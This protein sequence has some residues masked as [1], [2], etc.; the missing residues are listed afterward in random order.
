MV[1]KYVHNRFKLY[2]KSG[3][4]LQYTAFA[5]I[6]GALV[7]TVAINWERLLQFAIQNNLIKN[8][9]ICE[10]LVSKGVPFY[11]PLQSYYHSSYNR[12]NFDHITIAGQ[13]HHGMKRVEVWQQA[14]SLGQNTSIHRHDCEEVFVILSGAGQL[15]AKINGKIEVYPLEKNSTLIVPPNVVHQV[16]Q[17]GEE[18]LQI[19][20][21][22]SNP[23]MRLYT[24]SSWESDQEELIFPMFWD[25][26]C[27]PKF[28][29]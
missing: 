10:D 2:Q 21:V 16:R 17:S 19:L 1:Y 29:Q 5:S 27:P 23:P 7:L 18:L 15:S 4:G 25:Q 22:I 20:V 12:A 28:D 26:N 14:F 8:A 6:V 3:M 13:R 11:K 24:Y 9:M